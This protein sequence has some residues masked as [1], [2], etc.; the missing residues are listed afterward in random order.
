M[1]N[2]LQP[3]IFGEVLFDCFPDGEQVLGGAP[4]NVAWNLQAFGDKPRLV[5]RVGE[6]AL[7]KRI[8]KAMEE[9]GMDITAVQR[10]PQHQTGRVDVALINDEPHYSITPNC[11]YDFIDIT[12]ISYPEAEGILYHGTLGL[13]NRVAR[14]AFEALAS[15]PQLSIFLDVNLRPPWWQEDEVSGWL[16]QA[17]WVKLNQDELHQLGPASGDIQLDMA[18][19]Q[20]KYALELLIV[21]LG[22]EGAVVRSHDGV[23]HSVRPAGTQQFVD[24]VGAGDA[25]TA[26]FLHGLICGWPLTDILTA[27]QN[28]ASAVVGLRGATSTDPGI[29]KNAFNH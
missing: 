7:G 12:N 8:I 6:D 14:Q 25:F 2:K 18:R 10:D 5:S 1:S 13:R 15:H 16:K 28:F 11:A 9:W 21:T 20:K 3:I 29:Y 24:T 17:R 19:F 22:A 27:A 26:V 23:L 4:F